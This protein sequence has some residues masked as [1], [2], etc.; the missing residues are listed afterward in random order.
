[1]PSVV[2]TLL[3][4]STLPTASPS[5]TGSVVFVE[6]N[7]VVTAS[8]SD[9]AIADIINIAENSFGVNPGN[10]EAEVVYDI[11]GSIPISIDGEYIEEEIISALQNSMA[12]TLNIH[13]SDVVVDIDSQTGVA[14]YVISS[15]SA[16]DASN[17]Q[18]SLQLPSTRE[19]I[20]SQVAAAL[21][22]VSEVNH[23]LF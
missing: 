16:D 15:H 12:E 11:S 4:T 10:V 5:I 21:P 14:A 23:I 19:V 17:L 18:A 20:S 1:M 3:P 9:E 13:P 8:L 6:M 22:E 7:A 2:P